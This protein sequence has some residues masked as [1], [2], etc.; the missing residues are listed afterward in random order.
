MEKYQKGYHI[1]C[2]VIDVILADLAAAITF[3]NTAMNEEEGWMTN[4]LY[5][6]YIT[7]DERYKLKYEAKQ[8][9]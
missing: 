1:Y 5:R 2:R 9:E 7:E 3:S 8:E 4:H 6:L